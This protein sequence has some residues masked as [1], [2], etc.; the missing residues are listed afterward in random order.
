MVAYKEE[1]KL[2]TAEVDASI[3]AVFEYRNTL[4]KLQADD[5]LRFEARFKD[6]LLYTSRCV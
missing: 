4:D 2:D 3:E 1:F 6:C 5:L